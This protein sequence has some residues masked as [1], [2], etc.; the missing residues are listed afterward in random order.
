MRSRENLFSA[1]SQCR[2][3][4]SGR[5]ASV[6]SACLNPPASSQAQKL[7]WAVACQRDC[8]IASGAGPSAVVLPPRQRAMDTRTACMDDYSLASRACASSSWPRETASDCTDFGM[9]FILFL[10]AVCCGFVWSSTLLNSQWVLGRFRS[11]E[12]TSELQSH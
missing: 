6:V 4:G 8:G 7:C 11:E 9:P 3:L 10:A 12:H 2:Q 1:Y 5:V